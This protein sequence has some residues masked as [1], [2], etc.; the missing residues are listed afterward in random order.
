MVLSFLKRFKNDL[1][2]I[3]VSMFERLT[4]SFQCLLADAKMNRKKQ[5]FFFWRRWRRRKIKQYNS[6]LFDIEKQLYKQW[7][8]RFFPHLLQRTTN[9][10]NCRLWYGVMSAVFLLRFLSFFFLFFNLA[11]HILYGRVTWKFHSTEYG[12]FT[13]A[14]ASVQPYRRTGEVS[15]LMRINASDIKKLVTKLTFQPQTQHC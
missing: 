11:L 9:N 12:C 4:I 1:C 6:K 13:R 14:I 15:V 8:V 3:F 10:V 5:R 7:S 2:S